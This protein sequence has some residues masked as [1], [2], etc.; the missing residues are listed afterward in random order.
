ME[1][2]RFKSILCSH[3]NKNYFIDCNGPPHCPGCLSSLPKIIQRSSPLSKPK[4]K[5][6]EKGSITVKAVKEEEKKAKPKKS[7]L[8]KQIML[9]KKHPK[10]TKANSSKSK[11]AFPLKKRETSKISKKPKV[12]ARNSLQSRRYQSVE[13]YE[14]SSDPS[15]LSISSENSFMDIR[16]FEIQP[17]PQMASY[18]GDPY[19]ESHYTFRDDYSRH[20]HNLFFGVRPVR[21]SHNVFGPVFT[22]NIRELSDLFNYF[23]SLHPNTAN[24]ASPVS[25][26]KIKT[27]RITQELLKFNSTCTICQEAFQEGEYLKQLECEHFYHEE[28][29]VPWLQVKNNCPVCRLEI[30]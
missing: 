26:A 27:V 16:F 15:F 22:R 7:L 21:P 20:L 9:K 12:K 24:P 5:K 25:I 11:E 28:C 23:V 14:I 18:P 1:T 30:N 4:P 17:M 29:I 10:D 2:Y 3:C 13:R 8:K 19:L 6:L